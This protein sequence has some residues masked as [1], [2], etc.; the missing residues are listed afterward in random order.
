MPCF[1]EALNLEIFFLAL[2]GLPNDAKARRLTFRVIFPL[3]HGQEIS[4]NMALMDIACIHQIAFH[5]PAKANRTGEV[6][7]KSE[8]LNRLAGGLVKTQLL[9]FTTLFTMLFCFLLRYLLRYGRRQRM[10]FMFF[11]TFQ[12]AST[13]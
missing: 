2:M 4:M 13:V 1:L 8:W 12:T 7:H 5:S 11:G 9:V 10:T 3:T 6:V